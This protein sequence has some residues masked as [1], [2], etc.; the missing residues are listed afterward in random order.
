MR[1]GAAAVRA[2]I[3][4]AIV[5][6]C[7]LSSTAPENAAP[8]SAAPQPARLILL[9]S[10]HIGTRLLKLSLQTPALAGPTHLHVLLP[11]SYDAAPNRRYPVLYLLQ[12][13]VDDYTAWISEGNAEA[14][15]AGY[16]MIIVM[17]DAG[18][19]G[20]YSDW[21]NGG[22]FGPPQ[23]ETYH[24]RQLIPWIDAHY[25][26]V[27]A[28]R[29]RAIGGVSMGGFG[30]LSY[31]ARHPDLFAAVISF[32][33]LVDS[34]SLSDRATIPDTVF[35][36]WATQE[37]RWHGHNPC[38]LAG[39]LRGMDVSL[40]L[41]SGLP[42][43]GYLGVDPA[44]IIVH[45]QNTALHQRLLA[46]NVPHHWNDRGAG[47]HKW[48]TWQEDLS[49]ALPKL[50]KVFAD[51]P[52]AASPVSYKAIEPDYQVY[53]W[54][55]AL[56]RPGLEFSSLADADAQGFTLSGSGNA[57]VTTPPVYKP[58][59]TY[60]VSLNTG[61][62]LHSRTLRSTASGRLSIDVMLGPANPMQQ[63]TAATGD[64]DGTQVYTV[65]ATITA[66]SA[67][68]GTPRLSAAI[69]R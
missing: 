6:A 59:S 39:N 69:R 24:I 33:G 7:S 28:R 38:D 67:T 25:R 43:K 18:D 8:E 49:D 23:W 4:A 44:E 12:G 26:T 50:M 2:L 65:A 40:Y 20:Y 57:T 32:S 13:A 63:Y 52:A 35:G 45:W 16:P 42:G 15:S 61:G 1:G 47:R 53:G 68:I 34:N 66:A 10:Q 55:V 36:P 54:H 46:A 31:A 14:L 9:D 48:P 58:G 41:R 64:A 11:D 60:T 30:A 56:D 62:A 51:P 17:P 29:G 19:E 27:A 22:A 21:Y 37:V 3:A 5:S